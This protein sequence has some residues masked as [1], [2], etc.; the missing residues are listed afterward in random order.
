VLVCSVSL[1]PPR[2]IASTI[3][4]AVTARD[5][6]ASVSAIVSALVDDPVSAIETVDAYLGDIMIEA[7]SAADIVDV[8]FAY[9]AGVDEAATSADAPD[10]T[11]A[12]LAARA[13]MLE[14]V[15][16]N[17]DG[18][19]RQANVNGVMVNL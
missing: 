11:L 15:F 3:A 13:A 12:A 16:V 2:V 7:A 4:E 8:I 1:H 19:L 17:S 10:A 9:T 14:G 5:T 18:T 6:A